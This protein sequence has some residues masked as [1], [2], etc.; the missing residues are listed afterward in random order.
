LELTATDNLTLERISCRCPVVGTWK[1]GFIYQPRAVGQS[2]AQHN[3]LPVAA[4]LLE[5]EPL[6]VVAERV[7]MA[8]HMLRW[9]VSRID[10]SRPYYLPFQPTLRSSRYELERP[11]LGPRSITP[12]S[13][14]STTQSGAFSEA[15]PRA[16]SRVAAGGGRLPKAG[17][18]RAS[19]SPRWDPGEANAHGG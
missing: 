4:R 19:P 3:L 10:R 11:T 1:N 2:E 9:L 8:G 15:W 6:R 5:G 18:R 17:E 7:D 14:K 13:S 12:G 16:V